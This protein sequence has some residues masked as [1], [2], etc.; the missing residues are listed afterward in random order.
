MRLAFI[1]VTH[2]PLCLGSS[3]RV[4]LGGVNLKIVLDR[5]RIELTKVHDTVG[6]LV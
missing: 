2:E 4:G 5:A 6:A 3:P 1:P